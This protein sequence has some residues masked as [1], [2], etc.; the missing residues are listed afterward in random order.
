MSSRNRPKLASVI[1]TLSFRKAKCASACAEFSEHDTDAQ[2][3]DTRVTAE[4]TYPA[5]TTA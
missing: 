5:A 2:G 3:S 4:L 1:V